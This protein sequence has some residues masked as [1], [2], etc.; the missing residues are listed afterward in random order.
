[1]IFAILITSFFVFVHADIVGDDVVV[2]A[3]IDNQ[4]IINTLHTTLNTSQAGYNQT[5]WYS[6]NS[7]IFN[8]TICNDTSEC[9]MQL[10]FSHQGYFNL[11][12]WANQTNG[13]QTSTTINNLFVGNRT[14]Y[15]YSATY[16]NITMWAWDTGNTGTNLHP[17]TTLHPSF[18]D[19]EITADSD[20]DSS[21]NVRESD[22]GNAG[23]GWY[24]VFLFKGLINGIN[25]NEI[26][27]LNWTWEGQTNHNDQIKLW[28]W[29]NSASSYYLITNGGGIANTD[30]SLSAS[31]T[32]ASN[33]INSSNYTH[34]WVEAPDVYGE[35]TLSVDFVKLEITYYTANSPPNT[36]TLIIPSNGQSQNY[37]H[38]IY[39]NFSVTDPDSDNM[40]Y[41]I[42]MDTN[43]DPTT[44]IN[45]TE[46]EISGSSYFYNHTQA[47]GFDDGVY[48]WKV[49]A[50]DGVNNQNVSSPI[51]SFKLSTQAP[52]INLN[53]PN[54]E[55][56]FN[57][58]TNIYFNF[59]ALDTEG[60]SSC[61]LYEN[62][63]SSWNMNYSWVNPNN[64][65]MNYTI[66][67]VPE[68][69]YKWNIVCNDTINNL[70]M[71]INRT[72]TV[73]TI[74]PSIIIN[75]VTTITDSQT[76]SFNASFSDTNLNTSYCKYSIYN[77][78]GAIDG[79]N[80]NVSMTCGAVISAT[81]TNYSSFNLTVLAR[82]NAGNENVSLPYNFTVSQSSENPTGGGSSAPSE[83]TPIINQTY[84]GD[85][86]CQKD[87]GED[88]QSCYKD[89]GPNY[90]TLITSCFSKDPEIRK[91]CLFLQSNTWLVI[92]IVM[93]G[94][95]AF[96]IL[97]QTRKFK[98]Y[99]TMQKV[100]KK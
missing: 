18:F 77:L 19:T 15:N 79:T 27:L 45:L 84:C 3:P 36:P 17:S 6:I 86:I 44:I 56:Y 72:F 99:R 95:F 57:N 74:K 28:L 49:Y 47:G 41:V 23:T 52:S 22:I 40:T 85:G 1:M 63:T 13:T 75:S 96:T 70:G 7:G 16:Q 60:L 73:D 32:N 65:T 76:I 21:D 78:A 37:N 9:Q 4:E 91:G 81:V 90:D 51:Y 24:G 43:T 58:G 83:E 12:V 82:D 97:F 14:E 69:Y 39:F 25:I 67:T 10:N 93:I 5:I 42:F 26:T 87:M 71:A 2:N 33:F 29:N 38:S 100:E 50:S 54:I 61:Q 55:Q 92:L 34:L 30:Y 11:T 88:F 8:A 46:N 80:N 94:I 48:Y 59:T 64:N 31:N 62:W 66:L 68:G 53:Y 98:R 89:C 20:L 35:N